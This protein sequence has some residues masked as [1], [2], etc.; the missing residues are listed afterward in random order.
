M[1]RQL[2]DKLLRVIAKTIDDFLDA[3]IDITCPHCNG[4]IN[5][6]TFEDIENWLKGEK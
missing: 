3:K 6:I 4:M 2:E 5:Q 1:Q